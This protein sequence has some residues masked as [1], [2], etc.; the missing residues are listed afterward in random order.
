[1]TYQCITDYPFTTELPVVH[2]MKI[3]IQHQLMMQQMLTGW[4]FCS[5]SCV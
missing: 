1:M 3:H 5:I 2:M 4:N